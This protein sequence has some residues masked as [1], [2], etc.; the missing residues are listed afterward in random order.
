M[1]LGA[2]R[3][4]ELGHMFQRTGRVPAFGAPPQLRCLTQ[5]PGT[6]SLVCSCHVC[7]SSLRLGRGWKPACPEA[8][9]R[10]G[11]ESD[12]IARPP[13]LRSRQLCN[14]CVCAAS[15][16]AAPLNRAHSGAL[17]QYAH[18]PQR[19]RRPPTRS[20]VPIERRRSQLPRHTR[21]AQRAR[22]APSRPQIVEFCGPF[23]GNGRASGPELDSARLSAASASWRDAQRIGG[24]AHTTHGSECA[25][26]EDSSSRA[27]EDAAAAPSPSAAFV[28]FPT[29]KSSGDLPCELSCRPSHP[30]ASSS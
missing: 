30:L 13:Q 27:Q 15:P 9:Q 6:T 14:A 10:E 3:L 1:S 26:N 19:E 2:L 28:S 16:D 18:R 29:A 17:S 11:F 20:P 21:L 23:I 24:S 7:G 8:I 22:H 4:G 5:A 12:C 25:H